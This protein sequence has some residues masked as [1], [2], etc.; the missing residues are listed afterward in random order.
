MIPD[1]SKHGIMTI[2]GK[3]IPA[4]IPD[5]RPKLEALQSIQT[6]KSVDRARLQISFEECNV[7]SST[8]SWTFWNVMFLLTT[9]NSPK[10]VCIFCKV[11]LFF[12]IPGHGHK[13][14]NLSDFFCWHLSASIPSGV[15]QIEL[16]MRPDHLNIRI[17]M[18]HRVIEWAKKHVSMNTDIYVSSYI[19]SHPRL[20]F[21]SPVRVRLHSRNPLPELFFFLNY[22][23]FALLNRAE[24]RCHVKTPQKIQ[25]YICEIAYL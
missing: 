5:R 20:R 19:Q 16:S 8:G 9:C 15:G 2:S 1:L 18:R 17:L 11:K 10:K 21:I 13:V 3:L 12:S 14:Q 25:S 24:V 7:A 22:L 4:S 6:C 23:P